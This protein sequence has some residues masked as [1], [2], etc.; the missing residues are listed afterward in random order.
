MNSVNSTTRAVGLIAIYHCEFLSESNQKPDLTKQLSL[1]D[2]VFVRPGSGQCSQRQKGASLA[3][4]AG[5]L[6][7][8][9]HRC[10][11]LSKMTSSPPAY[12][13]DQQSLPLIYSLK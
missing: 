10:T 2:G 4:G 11:P 6:R 1:K 12:G 13:I 3:P 5:G 9:T 7:I 8:D